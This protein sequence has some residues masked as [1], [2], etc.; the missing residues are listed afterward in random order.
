[1]RFTTLIKNPADWMKGSGLHSDVVMTSRVRLARN[2][3]G[4]H[5]PGYSQEKD[6]VEMMQAVRPV[7]E[8]LPEM[9]SGFSEDYSSMSK[10]KKQVLVERH[11]ISREHAARSAGCAVVVDKKQSI[12]IMINEEDHFRMQGIRPG[13]SLRQAYESIDAVDTELASQLPYAFDK[14]LGF[15][16]ACPTNLGTGMRAS[17]MLHL[18]GLVLTEQVGQVMKAVNK[19]G[20]AVRGLYGEGTEALGNLFQ[21]S[22]QQTLGEKEADI[23]LQ[24]EKVVESV[25]RSEQNARL[26]LHED[27]PVTVRDRVG[28]A[29]AILSHAHILASKEALE[30]LSMLRLGA[31]LDIVPN[32]DRSVLDMLL[33][34]IQPAHLQLRANR[35]LSAEERDVLRAEITRDRLQSVGSPGIVSNKQTPPE[36]EAPSAP[37]D[38]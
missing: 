36:P 38:E 20:L 12:S 8:G 7:I 15:L 24:I 19:I 16:T 18:P 31:D 28:R 22:N 27:H 10:I 33:L 25:V 1:M 4:F 13:L 34:E 26:K 11:L 9:K 21:I 14:E 35:E 5:F 6:R 2:L 23:I 37:H 29:F 30:L 32:C 3:R 17:V